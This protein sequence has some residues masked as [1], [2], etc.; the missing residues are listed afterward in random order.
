M[1]RPKY[2]DVIH[3]KLN[4]HMLMKQN[5]NKLT[6]LTQWKQLRE[7]IE[8]CDVKLDFIRPK[9][10]LVDMVF[11]ANGG[12]V[13]KNKAIVSRFNAIPRMPESLEYFR[14]FTNKG[15]NTHVAT[16][17]FEGAGDGLFSHNKKHLWLGHGFRTHKESH[18]EVDDI[19][20]DND[21]EIHSLQLVDS[22][23]YHLD[24]CFCP[25]GYNDLMLYEKAFTKESLYK[26]YDVYGEEHCIKVND[27]DAINFAC[28]SISLANNNNTIST[29]LGNKFSEEL[30]GKLVDFNYSILENNMSEFLLSGGS[31]KCCVLDIEKQDNIDNISYKIDYN[32]N[33]NNYHNI[34]YK[35]SKKNDPEFRYLVYNNDR[36]DKDYIV[37]NN[38]MIY[39]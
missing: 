34:N 13:F 8:K 24:T 15:Y 21:L 19:L 22:L 6:A 4:S 33:Y 17:D 31:T 11:A 14:Y 12:L 23:W 35:Y 20:S 27:E 18:Y 32:N 28:N 39:G 36:D 37:G 29:I 2:F 30:K 5:V 7:K 38:M 16:Y 25:I 3:Y 26:I 9:R 1:C 10:G